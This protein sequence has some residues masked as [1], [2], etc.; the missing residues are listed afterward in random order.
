MA[1]TTSTFPP[2]GKIAL[3]NCD[4]TAPEFIASYGNITNLFTS[5]Y[6]KFLI[7]LTGGESSIGLK[8]VQDP[9]GLPEVMKSFRVDPFDA[10]NRH[11][12]A[13]VEVYDSVIV[14]GSGLNINGGD[15][16]I[17]ELGKFL[18]DTAV[19]HQK[20]KLIGVCFGHQLIARA[21]FG[22]EVKLNPHGYQI[23]PFDVALNETGRVLFPGRADL[24][25]PMFHQKAV[26]TQERL[27][28]FAKMCEEEPYQVPRGR[29]GQLGEYRI[30]G[31]TEK[32]E[33]QGMVSVSGDIGGDDKLDVDD[34]HIF[35]CQGHPE[36]TSGM[37]SLLLNLNEEHIDPEVVADARRRI[38]AFRG[39]LDWFVLSRL[40]WAL[41]TRHS[42]VLSGA[43][44]EPS[45]VSR[46][47]G[48]RSG[49]SVFVLVADT[50]STHRVPV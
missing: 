26:F 28:A 5:L 37:M 19:H 50:N 45:K 2:H 9:L 39:T 40:M 13:D 16:W 14:S 4:A 7:E 20:V 36:L 31:H 25:I 22:L 6:T 47:L 18:H 33:N 15:L 11:L 44:C 23:G 41:S 29:H 1:T 38:A 34:I 21:V 24:T 42:Y 8:S 17:E 10:V 46:G 43:S 12:P 3:L 30:W 35:T 49:E 27:A 48:E 32:V